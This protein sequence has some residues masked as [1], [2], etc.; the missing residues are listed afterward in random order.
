MANLIKQ[1]KFLSLILRHDPGAVGVT[2]DSHGW[3]EVDVLLQAIQRTRPQFSKEMLNKIVETNDKKRFA[4]SEDG[5]RIRASQGHSIGVDLD[6]K[7]SKPPEILFHGTALRNL[8]SIREQGLHSAARDHV[9]LSPNEITAHKVGMRHG[10][11]VILR[12]KAGSMAEAGSI[13]YLSEN[14]VWLTESVPVEFIEFP[15]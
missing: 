4:F 7:P 15:S 8:D 10:N 13:F 2:L 14:G 11:P 1:S 12:I 6:L 9:H 5:K 3:I